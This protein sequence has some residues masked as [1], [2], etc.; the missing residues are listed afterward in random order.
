MLGLATFKL[1][2]M[3]FLFNIVRNNQDVLISFGFDHESNYVSL[4]IFFKLYE[5]F[6]FILNIFTNYFIRR[7]EYQADKFAAEC[8]PHNRINNSKTYAV[9]LQRSLIKVF[10]N[11][12]SSLNPDSMYS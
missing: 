8:N 10:K 7:V 4:M 6:F 5:I 1:G 2:L 12:K 3:F 11:N 9:A